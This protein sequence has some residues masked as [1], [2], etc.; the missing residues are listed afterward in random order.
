MPD[1]QSS[2]FDGNI[3]TQMSNASNSNSHKVA[4]IFQSVSCEAETSVGVK[5]Q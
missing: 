3:F 2:N 1:M 5:E 4:N